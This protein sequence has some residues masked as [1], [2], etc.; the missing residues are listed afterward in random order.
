MDASGYGSPSP[1]TSPSTPIR[2][3][4]PGITM[5]NL[6]AYLRLATDNLN[7]PDW[8]YPEE[9]VIYNLIIQ[10]ANTSN[11]PYGRLLKQTID[12]LY[13]QVP[14]NQRGGQNFVT[15]QA[16]ARF[17]TYLED[18]LKTEQ[19]S[20]PKR[21]IFIQPTNE[22]LIWPTGELPAP[23]FDSYRRLIMSY[24]K[25]ETVDQPQLD[26][27]EVVFYQ[28]LIDLYR[29]TGELPEQLMEGYFH[30]YN[31]N[32]PV[33]MPPVDKFIALRRLRRFLA[34]VA[35]DLLVPLLLI[36]RS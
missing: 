11:V 3:W 2:E 25:T 5:E 7:T 33:P 30:S 35:P 16:L 12:Y 8:Y 24:F 17:K 36:H 31:N 23:D 9:E 20:S 28:H 6:L 14:I 34:Q 22:P 27:Q 18:K 32:T 15:K 4:P 21:Q 26:P 1:P 29:E 19:T 13:Q 10:A